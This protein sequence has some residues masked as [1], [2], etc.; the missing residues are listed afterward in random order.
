[1]KRRA[2]GFELKKAYFDCL[3]Q[4]CKSAEE[5]KKQMSLLDLLQA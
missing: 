4:N 2:L 1:M 3:V 5:G